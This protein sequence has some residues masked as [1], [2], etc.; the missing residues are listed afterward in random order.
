MGHFR[1]GSIRPGSIDVLTIPLFARAWLVGTS[2]RTSRSA[3][4]LDNGRVLRGPQSVTKSSG[5]NSDH[6]LH[7]LVGLLF[8]PWITL[9]VILVFFAIRVEQRTDCGGRS[10]A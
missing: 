8:D 7:G 9:I 10:A 5:S 1:P 6:D 3:V 2:G 4:P